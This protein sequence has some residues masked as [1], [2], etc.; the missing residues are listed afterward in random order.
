MSPLPG[1]FILIFFRLSLGD[2]F[3]FHYFLSL[4]QK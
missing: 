1:F 4:S 3:F 2:S